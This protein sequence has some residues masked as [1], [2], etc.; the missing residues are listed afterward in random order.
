MIR[1]TGQAGQSFLFVL[2]TRDV[3]FRTRRGAAPGATNIFNLLRGRICAQRPGGSASL[4]RPVLLLFMMLPRAT[5]LG[6]CPWPIQ[7]ILT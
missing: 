4:L 3:L 2:A 6:G 5:A 1:A 7:D